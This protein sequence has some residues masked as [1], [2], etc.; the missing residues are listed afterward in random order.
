MRHIEEVY[1]GQ[2]RFGFI[3]GGLVKNAAQFSDPLNKIGGPKMAEQVAVHWEEASRRHGMP[4]DAAVWLDMKDEFSS[5]WP[6]NIAFKAAEMQ[7]QE[8]ARKFL[9]RLR[10]AAAAERRFIHRREVQS[11]LAQEVGLDHER[12]I[13]DLDSGAAEA[14]FQRDLE[15]CREKEVTG[16]PSFQIRNRSG[17]EFMFFGYQPFPK[18]VELFQRLAGGELEVREIAADEDSVLAFIRKY[19]KVAPREVAEVFSLSDAEVED[20]ITR[21]ENRGSIS[22]RQAGN[23]WFLSA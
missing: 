10:E 13:L 20:W 1:D 6:A 3:M 4:V 18:F 19:G 21:L 16:F 15:E 17:K 2:M 5:T 9:R 22:R 8:L 7:D 12:F 14:A 23:S 11:A